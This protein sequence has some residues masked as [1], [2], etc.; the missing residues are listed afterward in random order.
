MRQRANPLLEDPTRLLNH[1]VSHGIITMEFLYQSG[2]FA[3]KALII[4][5]LLVGFVVFIVSLVMRQT[6]PQVPEHIE[7]VKLNDR[8]QREKETLQ[9]SSMDEVSAVNQHKLQ[10]NQEKAERKAQKKALKKPPVIADGKS[11]EDGQHARVFVLD[12]DGDLQATAVGQLRRALS[13]V[14]AVATT[15]D[16]VVVR[17][18]SGGGVVHAYGLAASQLERVRA[19]GVKLTVCVDKVAASGGYM[20]ACVASQLLCAPFAVIGSIGV[21]AQLPNFHR[22]LKK[23][24]VDFELLT[25]GQYKRTLTVFGENTED[26]RQKFREDLEDTHQMF[27]EYV[28]AQRPGLD[29]ARVATGEIWLG[30]RALEMGLV[31]GLMTSDEYLVSACERATVLEVKFVVRKKLQDRV[32]ESLEGS[33]ERVVSKLWQRSNARGWMS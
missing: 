20:M 4:V 24:D 26:G 16:E 11:E 22:L 6:G 27:K 2:L 25:A 1:R 30:K 13:A 18:D 14:L 23:H 5:A 3:T 17:V 21:V 29:I 19:R 32:L 8:L 10:R 28:A 12:F 9:Y 7:V 33:A 31:D 15:Q